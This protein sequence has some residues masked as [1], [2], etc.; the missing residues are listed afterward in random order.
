MRVHRVDWYHHLPGHVKEIILRLQTAGKSAFVAGGAVRDLLL[1]AKPKDFDLVSDATPDEIAALFPKTL[2]VGKQFGIMVV[3]TD[4]GPV[5]VARFRADGAYAD[6]RHPTGVTFSS[7]EEDAKR[8]DFTINALFYDAAAG[9]VIDYVDGLPDIDRRIIRCVGSPKARFEE[10]ALRM[11]RAIRFQAQLDFALDPDIISAIRS[12]ASRL[13]LVSRERITQ[14]L[15]RMFQSDQPQVGING[16]VETGLWS[17]I[18]DVLEPTE[19]VLR[20]FEEIGPTYTAGFQKKAP[21]ALYYGALSLWVPGLDPAQKLVLPKATK[22]LFGEL[23]D[24]I[25]QLRAYPKLELADRKTA[26]ASPNFSI[27]WTLLT[28]QHETAQSWLARLPIERA[29]AEKSNRL[30]PAP[31]LGGKDLM[32]LG[33]PAGP[34]IKTLLGQVRREQL[35]EKI[36]TREQALAVVEKLK[37]K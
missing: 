25:S 8:R 23:P 11:M 22:A 16:L 15:E 29:E 6:G 27:A 34:Q 12:L 17:Q 2:D 32:D 3:V 9:Q 31:L 20:W 21:T 26:L 1:G 36:S 14:E 18:F 7:P 28:V 33:I 10:D 5:E 13:A 30:N 37:S 24:E 4:G 19:E 35:N